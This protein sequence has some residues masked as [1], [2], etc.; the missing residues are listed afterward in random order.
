MNIREIL[1][2]HWGKVL[3]LVL[4]ASAVV[5]A[6]WLLVHSDERT[7]AQAYHCPMH[8]SYTSER[9]GDCPI[10]GMRL[11][12][13]AQNS[14]AATED[15]Y[16]CPMHPKVQQHEPGTC[17]QCG[18]DL[19]KQG[20]AGVAAPATTSD[21]YVCP[22]HPDVQQHEPGRCP[23][24]GMDLVKQGAAGIAAP[25]TTSD[26][27]VCPMHPDVQQHEPGRCPKCGMDL[28]KQSP[29]ASPGTVTLDGLAPISMTGN[30][31][32]LAGVRIQEAEAGELAATIRA[33]GNVVEDESRV[34]RVTTKVSGWVERLHVNAVG[35]FVTA[36]QPLV[37]L[38]SPELLASQE[39]YL[40][41]R[42]TAADFE[43]SSL[44]EVRRGG[45]D[46]ADAARR[47]LELFDVPPSF[48]AGIERS[49]LTERTITLR[50]PFNGY[51]TEKP[52]V[53]GQRIDAGTPLMTVVDFSRVWVVAELYEIEASAAR[54]G[55][56]AMVSLQHDPSVR[57]SG[58]VSLVY[59]TMDAASRTIRVR[60]EFAN[61][62]LV[63]KPGMF[64]NVEL[65]RDR[66]RG[67]LVADSAVID[68]GTRQIVFVEAEPGRFEPREVKVGLRHDGR[69]IIESGLHAGERVAVAANFLLDSESRLRA[70]I[71]GGR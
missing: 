14:A 33:V 15:V 5:A 67:V 60:L 37:D 69:V 32:T 47:R 43:R 8:P 61:P 70:A 21:L 65:D 54:A 63:L 7:R 9:P 39:E 19:V 40:R 3:L 29:H 46:L 16:Y 34:R 68:T 42:Q 59:P 28:V 6:P 38:Y 45:R 12:P 30:Q 18:M 35:Q 48:I 27:Y 41:A 36:G 66:A 25:A 57:L 51:V 58:R 64:V 62:R 2:Q 50:A 4:L 26:L 10:C 55:R 22:M 52:V 44:D 11:V 71:G 49:G 31:S 17:P 1:R 13:T 20:A 23:K 53:E 56:P 24:C